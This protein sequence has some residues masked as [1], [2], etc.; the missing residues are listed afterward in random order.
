MSQC[1]HVPYATRTLFDSSNYGY[2]HGFRI[3][4]LFKEK[5]VKLKEEDP[6]FLVTMLKKFHQ[7]CRLCV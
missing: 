4:N 1:G 3:L 5:I 2:L 6:H 7:I